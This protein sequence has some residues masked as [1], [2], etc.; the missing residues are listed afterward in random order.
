MLVWIVP[1]LC[2]R[3]S[4]RPRSQSVCIPHVESCAAITVH[5]H[6]RYCGRA[7][8]MVSRDGGTRPILDLAQ[9]GFTARCRNT[10]YTRCKS[11]G[12]RGTAP[13]QRCTVY[14]HP[15]PQPPPA[16]GLLRY[17]L[18]CFIFCRLL[19]FTPE[20]MHLSA[21]NLAFTFRP[22]EV[23]KHRRGRSCFL[24]SCMF[25]SRR[26]P[27]ETSG[28]CSLFVYCT[29]APRRVFLVTSF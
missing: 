25:G 9:R 15:A 17:A 29:V 5:Y 11:A 24:F 22:V 19:F 28:W 16:G 20:A 12:T 10:F 27:M 6:T 23:K 8:L 2:G 13:M 26:V 14:P 18:S 21:P 4:T 7:D 1:S 3:G